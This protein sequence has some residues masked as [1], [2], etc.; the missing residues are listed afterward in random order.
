MANIAAAVGGGAVVDVVNAVH[1][2][3]SSIKQR[4]DAAKHLPETVSRCVHTIDQIEGAVD[5]VGDDTAT[6][7]TMQTIRDLLKALE[8]LIERLESK[9]ATVAGSACGRCFGMMTH[10]KD[11]MRAEEELQDT[12]NELRKQLDLLVKSTE[13]SKYANRR[14][15]VLK[16]R[17][18]RKFWDA[19]FGEDR[20]ASLEALGEALRFEASE[21][22]LEVDLDAVVPICK[23]VFAGKEQVSVLQFGEVFSKPIPETLVELSK[24]TLAASHM[25]KVKV[26]RMPQREEDREIDAGMLMCRETDSLAGLRSLIKKHALELHEQD[27]DDESGDEDCSRPATPLLRDEPTDE[28]MDPELE[29]LRQGKFAFFLD[30]GDTR[31]R[32]KQ[33]R[34]FC[35][36]DYIDRVV[37]VRNSDLPNSKESLPGQISRRGSDATS[38]AVSEISEPAEIDIAEHVMRV[39]MENSA[40]TIRFE[41]VLDDERMLLTLKKVAVKRSIGEEAVNF[42]V[43]LKA[44]RCAASKAVPDLEQLRAGAWKIMLRFFQNTSSF[45]LPISSFVQTQTESK[46]RRVAGGALPGEAGN[47]RAILG[48]FN[49]AQV[50]VEEALK[51]CL[52]GI[53][54]AQRHEMRVTSPIAEL[55]ADIKRVVIV[56]GGYLGT[57]VA[58]QLDLMD[59]YHVTLIDPKEYFEDVTAQPKAIVSPGDSLGDTASYWPRSVIPYKG[60]TIIN[61]TVIT[62]FVSAV[63]KD[64][65]QVG[66]KRKVVKYDYLVLATGSSYSSNIKAPNASLAFRHKQMT[67]EYQAI[68]DATSVLIIGGGLVGC[69]ICGD[70]KE[71]FPDKKVTIVQRGPAFVPRV[72]GG[73]EK[74]C[75]VWDDLGVDWHVN[76]EIED[77]DEMAGTYTA[78]SGKVFNADKVYLCSG[79]TANTGFLYDGQTDSRFTAAMDRRNFLNT[80]KTGQVKGFDNV[81]CGGDMVSVEMHRSFGGHAGERTAQSASSHGALIARNIIRMAT[82]ET[83][84]EKLVRWDTTKNS[85]KALAVVSLGKTRA[86]FCADRELGIKMQQMYAGFGINFDLPADVLDDHGCGIGSFQ[87]LKDMVTGMVIGGQ[88]TDWRKGAEVGTDGQYSMSV[89]M[90][91]MHPEFVDPLAV[92]P[93]STENDPESVSGELSPSK[94]EPEPREDVEASIPDPPAQPS[95]TSRRRPAAVDDTD[96]TS[97]SPTLALSVPDVEDIDTALPSVKCAPP[98]A[99]SVTGGADP[100]TQINAPEDLQLVRSELS[101]VQIE[102]ASVQADKGLLEERVQAMEGEIMRHKLR[103]DMA[104]Q[105]LSEEKARA[106]AATKELESER[107]LR[108]QAEQAGAGLRQQL[109]ALETMQ[110]SPDMQ[111]LTAAP[112]R[113]LLNASVGQQQAAPGLVPVQTVQLMTAAISANALAM[114]SLANN[115]QGQSANP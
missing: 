38:D 47:S 65:V 32:K 83:D 34:I 84:R 103:A 21:Q 113:S 59:G 49:D 93:S 97:A 73:H 105:E 75:T 78:K 10:G 74:V 60:S 50:E 104:E 8:S 76:E 1:L 109:S 94:P 27:D 57:T 46:T 102:L 63:A 22:R 62:G 82:G 88:Q 86:L 43:E 85:G 92:P 66:S 106:D 18:A 17:D 4:I 107:R 3:G 29:F 36:T 56:G 42:L 2:I 13:L 24:R 101:Q 68:K 72:R 45:K 64:H 39:A 41:D 37:I 33:E 69:E 25:F 11:V 12:D 95:A 23:A 79:P 96:A 99:E 115:M 53:R 7:A 111:R 5:G 91:A 19:H 9:G 114:E 31:V 90:A 89:G 40:E 51:P 44:L 55:A 48:C 77:I 70:I 15:N 71:E 110:Q 112:T 20:E 35:G 30:D 81:F 58:K 61:G 108:E 80:H 16:Q 26:F 52:A 67:Q 6:A 87:S 14:S 54:K 100:A 98:H 28:Q